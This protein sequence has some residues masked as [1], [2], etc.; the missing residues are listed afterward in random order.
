M[1]LLRLFCA[2]LPP[3]CVTSSLVP[4]GS[5][6]LMVSVSLRMSLATATVLASRERVTEM[7][8]L[9]LPLR[10]EKLFRSAN[11]SSMLATWPRR[12]SSS[13]RRLTTTWLKPDGDSMRPTS[14]MLW[15]S[16][17]PRT[18]PTGAV[19]FWLRSAAT[20]SATET[21]NSRSFSARSSTVS[22]RLSAPLTLTM[23]T[24]LMPRNRSANW[25]SARR[26]ISAWL[27]CVADKASCMM[28]WAD[29]SMRWMMGS[30]ISLGSL[31]RTAAMAPRTS[32]AAS[33]MFLLKLKI[34]T[35]RALLSLAVERT[36]ST[37][38]ML[39]SDFS[40]R[41]MTSRSTVSG[42]APG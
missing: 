17:T 41:L 37:P 1:T 30:R 13:P 39:S 36:S 29:G 19:V 20:T 9:A 12:M 5:V 6:L 14:R 10:S 38:E 31:W 7:P 32:S 18:L 42:L 27:C 4:A 24:P 8:T 21:L 40:M 33:I 2:S 35:R 28:G 16:S 15:S 3:S 26:E 25:S 22:S 34:T 23:A 11:P